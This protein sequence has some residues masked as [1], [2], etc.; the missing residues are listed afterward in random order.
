MSAT[1]SIVPNI[2]LPAA[3]SSSATTSSSSGIKTISTS[4]NLKHATADAGELF[5]QAVSEQISRGSTA[6][7][8]ASKTPDT[9]SEW[10]R[11]LFADALNFTDAARGKAAKATFI[12]YSLWPAQRPADLVQLEEAEMEAAIKEGRPPV[13]SDALADKYKAYNTEFRKKNKEDCVKEAAEFFGRPY[14]DK[15]WPIITKDMLL[16]RS[17]ITRLFSEVELYERGMRSFSALSEYYLGTFRP[18]WQTFAKKYSK[19]KPVEQTR[20]FI[21]YVDEVI[22]GFSTDLV[23]HW[24]LELFDRLCDGDLNVIE[25]WPSDVIKADLIAK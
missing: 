20:G 25:M 2:E 16:I 6:A 21:G 10:V 13:I 7:T 24:P 1:P 15:L 23:F 17:I 3:E 4:G 9:F 14:N 12:G 8:P 19:A 5:R 18:I 11:K 22:S